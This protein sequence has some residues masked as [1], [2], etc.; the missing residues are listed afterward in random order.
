MLSGRTLSGQTSEALWI[1]ISHAQNLLSV[2]LN[3][4]LG[5]K[6]LLPYVQG[7]FGCCHV[8]VSVHPNAGL[9][10]EFGESR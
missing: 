9:P 2:G 6:Q 3:C 5:G 8:P 10:N 4:A 7:I 1:S